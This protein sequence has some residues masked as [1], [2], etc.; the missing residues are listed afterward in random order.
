MSV[1]QAMQDKGLCGGRGFGIPSGRLTVNLP[2]Q[3]GPLSA[4]SLLCAA[5]LDMKHKL[6][7]VWCTRLMMSLAN[8]VNML[9][10]QYVHMGAL[11][12]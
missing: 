5:V 3:L 11:D 6:H 1:A 7:N 4:K 10:E 2:S 9:H 8:S 12:C